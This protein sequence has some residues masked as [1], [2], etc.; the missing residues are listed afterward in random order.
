MPLGISQTRNWQAHSEEE[1]Y[2]LTEDGRLPSKDSKVPR[3]YH[4]GSSV[5]WMHEEAVERHRI[6]AMKLKTGARGILVPLLESTRLWFVVIM[7]GAGW[8]ICA[9]DAVP[10]A[11]SITKSRVA[12]V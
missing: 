8:E 2:E 1:L 5:D 4:D 10:T 3:K 11:F 12:V 6:H 7:A 9:K